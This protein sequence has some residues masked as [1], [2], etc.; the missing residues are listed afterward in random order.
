MPL[1]TD[2]VLGVLS[3]RLNPKCCFEHLAIH[4]MMGEPI[5]H[6]HNFQVDWL[7]SIRVLGIDLRNGLWILVHEKDAHGSGLRFLSKVAQIL[8]VGVPKKHG[9]QVDVEAEPHQ[10]FIS[11][12]AYCL[13]ENEFETGAVAGIFHVPSERLLD[14]HCSRVFAIGF[15]AITQ[16]MCVPLSGEA[17]H[18]F[19]IGV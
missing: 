11:T 2:V 10:Y 17:R 13:N 5:L 14:N 16:L 12:E 1:V 3:E 7:R 9:G 4:M 15:V 19:V 18:T 6:E 8:R